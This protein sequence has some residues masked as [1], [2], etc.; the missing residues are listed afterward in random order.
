[1]LRFAFRGERFAFGGQGFDLVETGLEG[2]GRAVSGAQ[3][4]GEGAGGA[5]RERD[6]GVAPE[7]E[8]GF[9]VVGVGVVTCVLIRQASVCDWANR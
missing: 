8:V 6:D 2:Q 4:I 5:G 3:P 1:M 9:G 7:G